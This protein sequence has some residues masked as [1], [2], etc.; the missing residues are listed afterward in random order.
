[1]TLALLVLALTSA[2][3]QAGACRKATQALSEVSPVVM[4]V[5]SEHLPY[6]QVSFLPDPASKGRV[7]VQVNEYRDEAG[8]TWRGVDHLAC[9]GRELQL[10][11]FVTDTRTGAVEDFEPALPW[12]RLPLREGETWSWRGTL[13][14]GTEEDSLQ[15]DAAVDFEVGAPQELVT[16]AGVFEAW[17]VGY[18]LSVGGRRPP[19]I[20]TISWYTSELVLV[21]RTREYFDAADQLERTDRWEIERLGE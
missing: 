21:Q 1:M 18:D 3:A 12:L 4:T 11:E 15:V 19:R 9:R 14:V 8:T 2:D 6:R 7:Y 20:H 10:H 5:T 17:P 16:S 13:T